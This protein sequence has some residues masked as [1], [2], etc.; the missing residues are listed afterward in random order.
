MLGESSRR[1]PKETAV[2]KKKAAEAKKAKEKVKKAK[3]K[4]A[5]R[6]IHLASQLEDALVEE[7]EEVDGAFPRRLSGKFSGLVST[8]IN[9]FTD[10]TT[11]C[12]NKKRYRA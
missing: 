12:R 9:F 8:D 10:V 5:V 7:S 1:T 3:E 2:A 11:R 6:Y 4:K